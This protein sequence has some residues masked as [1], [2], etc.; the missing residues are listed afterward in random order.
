[1]RRSDRISRSGIIFKWGPGP[2]K[3]RDRRRSRR[4]GRINGGGGDDGEPVRSPPRSAVIWRD[5]EG[6]QSV[7]VLDSAGRAAVIIRDRIIHS[8]HA[9][10]YI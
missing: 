6:V 10:R 3:R 4:E 1:M 9:S 2:D 8:W 7:A 5:R